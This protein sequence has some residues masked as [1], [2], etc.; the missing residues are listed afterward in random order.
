MVPKP[1]PL[2]IPMITGFELVLL[3]GVALV[4]GFVDAIAGG[5]GLLTVPALLAVGLPPHVALAT[6]KGQSTLGSAAALFRFW[7]EGLIDGRRAPRKIAAAMVGSFLGAALLLKAR[8]ETLRVIVLV[9]LIGVAIFMVLRPARATPRLVVPPQHVA[10]VG[11]LIAF[12]IGTYDGFFGPG[13]GT[14]LIVAG[15]SLLGQ[16]MVTASAEAKVVNFASNVAALIL[17]GWKGLV[18]LSVAVPMAGAQ[19]L[20]GFLGAHFAIRG[21]ER[22]VRKVL[23]A[24]VIGLVIKLT[25]DQFLVS[26]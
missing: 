18:L 14:L 12:L 21:G 23:L 10:A 5:G 20:G 2:D 26:R 8:P 13:T 4:G 7:R 25:R 22:F 9:L 24:V 3:V 1:M 19:I 6:N 17:F 11:V 16:S 15:V